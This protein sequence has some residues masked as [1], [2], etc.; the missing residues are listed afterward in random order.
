MRLH[1]ERL[2]AAE[3]PFQ[4]LE[5]NGGCGSFFTVYLNFRRFALLMT[6]FAQYPVLQPRLIW[7]TV[8]A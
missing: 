7:A 8:V 5:A 1:A 6:E 4:V 3:P 2:N